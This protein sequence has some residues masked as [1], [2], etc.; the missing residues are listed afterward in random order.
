M[1]LFFSF[2]IVKNVQSVVREAAEGTAAVMTSN[3]SSDSSSL[4]SSVGPS[5]GSVLQGTYQDGGVEKAIEARV[6]S[7]GQKVRR[8]RSFIQ[9]S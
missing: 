3:V 4:S 8:K 2:R 6:K 5:A 9:S 1:S 7:S